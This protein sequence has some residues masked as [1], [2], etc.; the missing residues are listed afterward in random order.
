MLS[1]LTVASSFAFFFAYPI[2][3][4]EIYDFDNI[5]GLSI[6]L[7]VG[8]VASDLT[9]KICSK[10]LLIESKEQKSSMLYRLSKDLASVN[11]EK[12][13][14]IAHFLQIQ[15]QMSTEPIHSRYFNREM[16]RITDFYICSMWV[17]RYFLTR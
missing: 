16:M 11:T 13:L 1:C 4:L 3:S 6:T 17:N 7:V 8:I 5:I 10:T 2:F 12:E 9:Q 14:Q 15:F